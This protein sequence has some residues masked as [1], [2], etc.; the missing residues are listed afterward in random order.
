LLSKAVSSLLMLGVRPVTLTLW[1][2]GSFCFQSKKINSPFF[3]RDL[4]KFLFKK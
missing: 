1:R 3:Q 2:R 4:Q